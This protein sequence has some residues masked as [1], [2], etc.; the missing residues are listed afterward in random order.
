MASAH[1]HPGLR[2]ELRGPDARNGVTL[3]VA[4][5]TTASWVF[6]NCRQPACT[7]E[8]AA[9]RGSPEETAPLRHIDISNISTANKKELDRWSCERKTVKKAVGSA[10]LQ[11]TGVQAE[12]GKFQC[13]QK[14][15]F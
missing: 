9:P 6:R 8:R 4:I 5:V 11:K 2:R 10:M 12:E 15:N 7:L 14:K 3:P 1:R 13:F